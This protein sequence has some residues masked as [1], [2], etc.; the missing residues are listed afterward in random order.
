MNAPEPAQNGLVQTRPEEPA[1]SKT[2][3]PLHILLVDDHAEVRLT[4]AAMLEELGH[5]VI[6]AANGKEALDALN[7]GAGACDLLISDYAMPHQSGT[8]FLREA[9]DLCPDVPALIITGYAD[10]ETIADRPE[11][12]EVLLKPFTPT[13]LDAAIARVCGAEAVPAR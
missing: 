7:N 10:A 6:K 12:V 8:D 2:T 5:T 13:M 9:R 1:I 4:T 3:R 11:G